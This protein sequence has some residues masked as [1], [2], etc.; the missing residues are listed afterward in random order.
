M[1][2]AIATIQALQTAVTG[3]PAA[4]QAAVQPAPPAVG[5]F[6]RT[7]LRAN[8]ANVLDYSSN[9]EHRKAYKAMTEPLFPQDQKFDVEPNQFQTFMN[10]LNVRARDIGL[11][12]PGQIALIPQNP[13]APLIG[14]YVNVIEEYG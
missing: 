10:L 11:M 7:P 5:P 1:N 6:I 2:A 12:E 3:L 4:I 13:I 9:K 14:P 8:I